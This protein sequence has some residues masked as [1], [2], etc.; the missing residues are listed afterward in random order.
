[1]LHALRAI[2]ID[3]HRKES[4]KPKHTPEQQR[5]IENRRL[6]ELYSSDPII[7]RRQQEE[8]LSKLKRA[9]DEKKGKMHDPEKLTAEE[10][11]MR[12]LV[13]DLLTTT[14]SKKS[15]TTFSFPIRQPENIP[16]QSY[17]LPSRV[18]ESRH[19]QAS[20]SSSSSS[21]SSISPQSDEA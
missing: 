7:R 4:K 20:S 10:E 16:N 14:E 19:N 6:D 5:D 17:V 2:H 21:S 9:L 1:M 3:V 12:R 15:K 13:A 11:E 18:P 8:M